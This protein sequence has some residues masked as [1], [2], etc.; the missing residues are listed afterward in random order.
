MNVQNALR[1]GLNEARRE[2]AHVASEAD[3]LDAMFLERGNDGG[4]ML[5]AFAAVGLNGERGEAAFPSS[6]ETGR[7]GF[8]RDDDGNFG[9]RDATRGDAIRDGEEVRAAAREQDAETMRHA[10]AR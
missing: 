1:K 5:C 8:I 2:Q 6:G 7:V 4:I 9:I 10:H 3:E